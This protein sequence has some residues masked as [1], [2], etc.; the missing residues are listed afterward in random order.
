[1]SKKKS[2]KSSIDLISTWSCSALLWALTVLLTTVSSLRSALIG[3]LHDRIVKSFKLLL[4][5]FKFAGI[6]ILVR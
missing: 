6:S 3:L 5:V 1:M 4:F 2:L